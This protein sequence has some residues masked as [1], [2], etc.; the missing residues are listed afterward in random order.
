M[1]KYPVSESFLSFQG[2]GLH[3]GRKA[4]FVRLFGCNVRC[5]WCDT[6]YS[7]QLKPERSEAAS[8]LAAAAARAKPEFAVIT[9]GEPCIYDLSPLLAELKA[10]SIAA[11]L[12][13]S[14][15][16]EIKTGGSRFDWITL[17]PKLFNKPSAESLRLAD[18]LKFVIASPDDL[19]QYAEF[20][21]LAP[22]AKAAWLQPEFSRSGDRELLGAIADFVS[23][24]GGIFRAGAQ[25]H[26]L[27]FAR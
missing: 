1:K 26:R 12:E 5:P 8:E 24:R 16:E 14:G 3:M 20:V 11:H 6:K 23:E 4:Y 9:G 10:R 21:E 15:T 13:T 22:N 2:E 7:W 19:P 25:L 17:S 27:Y 18:E